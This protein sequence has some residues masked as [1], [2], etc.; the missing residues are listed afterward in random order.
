MAELALYEELFRRESPI[1]RV[2]QERFH[3]HTDDREILALTFAPEANCPIGLFAVFG[4]A[5]GSFVSVH[6]NPRCALS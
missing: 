4:D 2:E 3:L 5:L 1:V 6:S